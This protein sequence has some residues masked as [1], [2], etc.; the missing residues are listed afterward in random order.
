MRIGSKL[1]LGV[2]ALVLGGCGVF[3][4]DLM[5]GVEVNGSG[6]MQIETIKAGIG[7]FA[8]EWKDYATQ[9]VDDSV[10]SD[11]GQPAQNAGSWT[12]TGKLKIA[13]GGAGMTVSEQWNVTGEKIAF[14]ASVKAQPAAPTQSLDVSFFLPVEDYAGKTVKIGDEEITLPAQKGEPGLKWFEGV[15]EVVVP[16]KDRNLV[17]R[18]TMTGALQDNREY[19]A[20]VFEIRL[21]FTPFEGE[22]S[23]SQ[24]SLELD[25]AAKK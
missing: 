25:L 18:G 17:L 3:A 8:P 9:L 10:E 16:L 11:Q 5:P 22:I 24:F 6:L 20:E 15:S 19:N 12:W 13:G 23:E 1:G 7:H 4:A 21:H 14:S 2:A